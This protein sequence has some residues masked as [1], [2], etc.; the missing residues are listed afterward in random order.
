V[1]AAQ[2][3]AAI[4]KNLGENRALC[5][6]EVAFREVT[7]FRSTRLQSAI[8]GKRLAEIQVLGEAQ[9]EFWAR[10]DALVR[11]MAD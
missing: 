8:P 4:S 5:R 9:A 3:V 1:V 11:P 2:R 7:G 6:W 10:D